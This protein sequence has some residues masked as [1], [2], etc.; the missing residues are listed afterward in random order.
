MYIIVKT[1]CDGDIEEL[2]TMIDDWKKWA[3][4]NHPSY[5]Y[6]VY[7][8][9]G[10]NFELVKNSDNGLH[11][12]MALYYWLPDE[13]PEVDFPHIIAEYEG[14]TRNDTV[15]KRVNEEIAKGAWDGIGERLGQLGIN[16]NLS[17]CGNITWFNE[18]DWYFVYG[19][20]IDGRYDLGY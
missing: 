7:E 8:W 13:D 15:P 14:R 16:D 17:S 10:N 12:G 11:E 3:N 5:F 6:E 1:N 18:N 4:R 2:I 20:Y 19:E 9:D